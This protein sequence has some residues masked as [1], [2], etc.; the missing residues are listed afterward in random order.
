MYKF[1]KIVLL[2]R[3]KD[4]SLLQKGSVESTTGFASLN[5]VV[6]TI[7]TGAA[8]KTVVEIGQ[9]WLFMLL[10]LLKMYT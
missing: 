10:M 8:T 1:I 3:K 6:I 7:A 2:T 5:K 4:I 9:M